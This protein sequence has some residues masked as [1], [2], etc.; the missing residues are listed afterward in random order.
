MCRGRNTTSPDSLKR[1]ICAASV[2]AVLAL[3]G[4]GTG[5]R[6]VEKSRSRT[7]FQELDRIRQLR[8]AAP[9]QRDPQL[10]VTS[11]DLVSTRETYRVEYLPILQDGLTE[12]DIRMLSCLHQFKLSPKPRY[13][14]SVVVVH[15]EVPV[16]ATVRVLP[17]ERSEHLL[18][19]RHC[20][21]SF[22]LKQNM[23][24]L[25]T[26]EDMLFVV[27]NGGARSCTVNV[28]CEL[29]RALAAELT[30]E[31]HAQ[32]EKQRRDA[33][34]RASLAD[35]LVEAA[36]GVRWAQD[37][38]DA[39]EYVLKHKTPTDGLTAKARQLE[40]VLVEEL[41]PACNRF[42]R[43]VAEYTREFGGDAL[44]NLAVRHGF[45]GLLR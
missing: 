28:P 37:R 34:R 4:C 40:S 39:T 21:A 31:R 32:E 5:Y 23:G 10:V 15:D 30:A 16:P 9:S 1:L 26:S 8:V 45:A 41:T 43:L 33:L 24:K 7:R 11:Y 25:S 44:Y 13:R 20:R 29:T 14:D 18:P 27:S 38:Y 2:V 42:G 6:F 12:G 3:C 22:G 19:D 35:S 17:T 36:R